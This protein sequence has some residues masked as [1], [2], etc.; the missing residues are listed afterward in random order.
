[1]PIASSGSTVNRRLSAQENSA[2][3]AMRRVDV[4]LRELQK[5]HNNLMKAIELGQATLP[6]I[7]RLNAVDEELKGLRAKRERRHHLRLICRRIA[8]DLSFEC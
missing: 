6:L 5:V 3:E 7:E 8:F 2:E 4:R 1:M